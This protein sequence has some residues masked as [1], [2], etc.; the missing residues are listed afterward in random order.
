LP[1]P[2]LDRRRRVHSGAV[3][4]ILPIAP[5][6]RPAGSAPPRGLTAA[7]IDSSKIETNPYL[8]TYRPKTNA[9]F[10]PPF[11]IVGEHEDLPHGVWTESYLTYGHR[12]L[13]FVAERQE[14]SRLNEIS[15]WL[16]SESVALR[17]YAA[18]ISS[19][20]FTQRATALVSADILALPYP[21]GGTLDLS[22]N[23]AILA[24]DIVGYYRDLIRLGDNSPALR[25]DATSAYS[26]FAAIYCKQIDHIYGDRLLHP[27]EPRHWPGITCFPFV[28]GDGNVDWSDADEL[29]D[30]LDAL[31]HEQRG[32]ALSVTRIARIYDGPFLY[33]VKPDR[34]RF[35]LRSVALRDADDTLADLRAQGF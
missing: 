3:A 27:L 10:T 32:S 24:A 1:R 12:L 23:E 8:P 25:N 2:R 9:H 7:G 19:S 30:K 26:D 6:R 20:L 17:A 31:L 14:L 28:F 15:H 33:L 29:R 21:R 13:G 4:E 22:D 16:D 18:G 34:L 5:Y 11:L 35:W